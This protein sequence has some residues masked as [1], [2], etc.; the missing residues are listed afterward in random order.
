MKVKALSGLELEV[1][2]IVWEIQAC[3]VRDVLTQITKDKELAYTTI[4]T[5]LQRLHEKGLVTRNTKDFVVHYTPKISKTRY[6]KTVVGSFFTNFFQSFGDVAIASFAESV[7]ELPQE[8]K[9][10]FLKLLEK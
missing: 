4:A 3:S 10:Y 2:N 9:K 6:S 1:I 5:I 8:K 7:E